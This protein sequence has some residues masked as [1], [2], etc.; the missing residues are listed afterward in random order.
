MS[1]AD[2][3]ESIVAAYPRRIVGCQVVVLNFYQWAA[4]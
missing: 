2:I 4:G 3:G 1:T